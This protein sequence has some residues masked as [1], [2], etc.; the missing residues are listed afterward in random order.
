MVLRHESHVFTTK[1]VP[2]GSTDEK[3]TYV[4]KKLVFKLENFYEEILNKTW[5]TKMVNL[6][7]NKWEE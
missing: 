5:I 4:N 2:L 6:P 1:R 7:L 3:S